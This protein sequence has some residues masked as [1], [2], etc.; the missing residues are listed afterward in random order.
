MKGQQ[1]PDGRQVEEQ[2]VVRALAELIDRYGVMQLQDPR[3]LHSLLSDQLGADATR[4][5]RELNVVVSAASAQIP[6]ALLSGTPTSL[7]DLVDRLVA[8]TGL[9]PIAARWAVQVWADLVGSMEPLGRQGGSAEPTVTGLAPPAS[10]RSSQPIQ[11]VPGGR[12]RWWILGGASALAI[13]ALVVTLLWIGRSRAAVEIVLEGVPTPGPDPFAPDF[14]VPPESA[15]SPVVAPPPAVPSGHASRVTTLPGST[16]GLYGG[17]SDGTSCNRDGIAEFLVANPDKAQAW[18]D[19]LNADPML[20]WHGG[21]RLT[22]RDISAYVAELTPVV[23]RTATRVTN[24]GYRDGRL[25]PF[26][27]ILQEGTPVL[28]DVYGT[29]RVRCKSGNPLRPLKST[30]AIRSFAG[31]AWAGF[32]PSNLTAVSPAD[33]PIPEFGLIDVVTGERFRRPTGTTGD[34]DIAQVVEEANI[35]GTHMLRFT[36]T[37]CVGIEA[38]EDLSKVETEPREFLVTNC[39]DEACTITRLDGTWANAITLTFDGMTWRGSGTIRPE[40]GFI[41][42]GVPNQSLFSIELSVASADIVEGVWTAQ[43]LRGSY[44]E[45]APSSRGCAAAHL[46]WNL[47][48]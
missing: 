38:C 24:H 4:C 32:D 2:R 41:C 9:A 23:L 34:R 8:E 22:M 39:N 13:L 15:P 40:Y 42:N 14:S 1:G 45:T 18:T 27:S 44:I 11:A 28:V 10:P 21:Q 6:A 25:A 37:S 26:Q 5:R 30:R 3:R 12:S 20:R 46:S 36:R 19:A 43:T 47:S 48:S 33:Q 7:D 35:S 17:I 31:Q 16:E 29:P